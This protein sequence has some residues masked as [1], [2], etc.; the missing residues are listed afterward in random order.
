MRTLAFI[1]SKEV[2]ETED[3]VAEQNTTRM[4]KNDENPIFN[5]FLPEQNT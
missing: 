4:K 5:L 1:P 3:K 2:T